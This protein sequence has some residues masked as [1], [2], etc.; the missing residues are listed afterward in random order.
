MERIIKVE[1]VKIPDS[2]VMV[3]IFEKRKTQ[4]GIVL[5]ENSE[6]VVRHGVIIAKGDQVPK[7]EID[8]V[9][10][11]YAINSVQAYQ[12]E[13]DGTKRKYMLCPAAALRLVVAPDNFDNS[14]EI[15]LKKE[16]EDKRKS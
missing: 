4:S 8:D 7:Y 14:K 16:F 15:V 13:R 2:Y 11:D 1:E 5:P 10:L 6:Y 3:E 9:V 12:S